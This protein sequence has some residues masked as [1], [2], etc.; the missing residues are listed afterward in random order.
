[1]KSIVKTAE[2]LIEQSGDFVHINK[3]LENLEIPDTEFNQIRARI[4][5]D[6]LSDGRFFFKGEEVNLTRKFTME[7]ISKIKSAYSVEKL[8][9]EE[10]K[11]EEETINLQTLR[12]ED[13]DLEEDSPLDVEDL[14][15]GD[16][17][18]FGIDDE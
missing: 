8:I 10:N 13:A 4:Y 17:N 6:L 16:L 5:T 12:G 9:L 2:E 7:E 18:L 3:I 15:E 1:M 14:I 11:L